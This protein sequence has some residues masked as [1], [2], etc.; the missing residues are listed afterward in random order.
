M[1]FGGNLHVSKVLSNLAVKYRNMN[2][3]ADQVLPSVPVTKESDSYYTW[4]RS[5][6]LP[7][8]LRAN[9]APANMATWGVSLSSYS[10]NEHALKDVVTDRDRA[11]SDE[12]QMD[13]ET[14]EFLTDK[15]LLRR[16]YEASKVLFTTGSWSNNTSLDTA[17]SWEYNTTTSAPIQ[18]VLSATAKIIKSSGVKPNVAILG[19]DAIDALKEN[20]NVYNRIQYVERAILTP[21]LIAALFDLDK[22]FVGTA[23]YDAGA[24]G[25]AESITSIWGPNA[26]IAYINPAAGMKALSAA[27]ML[28]ING[29]YKVKKWREEEVGG[30]YIE[31]SSMFVPKLVATA[32]GYYFSSVTAA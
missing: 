3:I 24:V 9:G 7:E 32:C 28:T 13:A 16:E 11:N 17:T 1:A 10:L 19:H 27:K 26:L 21:D 12:I 30:D 15:I 25:V 4:V 8:T 5:F 2:L 6:N 14:T 18:Q 20:P 29:G 23:V 22:V 31:V